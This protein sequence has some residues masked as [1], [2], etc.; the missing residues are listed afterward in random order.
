MKK[1][2]EYDIH[3]NLKDNYIHSCANCYAQGKKEAQ[4]T[5]KIAQIYAILAIIAIIAGITLLAIST[6]KFN[7][8]NQEITQCI[9]HYNKQINL[10][11]L[12]TPSTWQPTPYNFNITNYA[13]YNKSN[14]PQAPTPQS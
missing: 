2:N 4:K 9:N 5:I 1:I 13:Y 14:Q 10:H 8:I 7:Q 6:A 3:K 12:P 11:C